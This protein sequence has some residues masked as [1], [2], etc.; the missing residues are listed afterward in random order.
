MNDKT[1]D[2]ALI[3]NDGVEQPPVINPYMT[4][5]YK[6]NRIKTFSTKEYVEGILAGNSTI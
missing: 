1:K 4:N 2:S 3:V 5:F 6:K